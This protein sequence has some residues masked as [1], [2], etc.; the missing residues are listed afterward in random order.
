MKMLSRTGSGQTHWKRPPRCEV[1]K[2]GVTPVP[3]T[4]PPLPGAASVGGWRH[5]AGHR[6]PL[7]A[8]PPPT[9]VLKV[10]HSGTEWGQ[11][12]S[13]TSGGE[14]QAN[15]GEETQATRGRHLWG[16]QELESAMMSLGRTSPRHTHTHTHTHAG[17]VGILQPLLYPEEAPLA[18]RTPTPSPAR[19]SRRRRALEV[20][21]G[22]QQPPPS[23][24]CRPPKKTRSIRPKGASSSNHST[25]A[26]L[27]Q[28]R[29]Y[30]TKAEPTRHRSRSGGPCASLRG[31]PQR[32]GVSKEGKEEE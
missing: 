27:G 4:K 15:D 24:I 19:A 3:S 12:L 7:G 28:R 9:S 10:G 17:P 31:C 13:L 18:S 8:R 14:N 11:G 6:N 30:P 23:S 16:E 20:E 29:T 26:P 2:E 25:G 22:P 32:L 5:R 21:G 1:C